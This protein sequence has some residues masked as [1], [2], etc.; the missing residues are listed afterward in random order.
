[1]KRILTAV[2]LVLILAAICI[3][4]RI[5][6]VK[7]VSHMSDLL[8]EAENNSSLQTVENA[9]KIQS[10]WEQKKKL[11]MT[12][13][14]H[15]E[16]AEISDSIFALSELIRNGK[17]DEFISECRNAQNALRHFEHSEKITFE[18]IL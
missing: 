2:I 10:S 7:T 3:S 15:E 1:M 11:L 16:L 18:N 9:E 5:T 17:T 14:G 6:T 4:S 12:Y 8:N 13:T